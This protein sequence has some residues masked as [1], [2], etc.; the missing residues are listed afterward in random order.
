MQYVTQVVCY[1]ASQVVSRLGGS[2][3]V[4]IEASEG[5]EWEETAEAL[6][7]IFLGDAEIWYVHQTDCL[8]GGGEGRAAQSGCVRGVSFNHQYSWQQQPSGT[9]RLTA[10]LDGS[11]C[12]LPPPSC[13]ASSSGVVLLGVSCMLRECIGRK[14]WN[15]PPFVS[16]CCNHPYTC[17]RRPTSGSA[18][19]RGGQAPYISPDGHNICDIRFYEGLKLFGEDEPVRHQPPYMTVT[20]GW[21]AKNWVLMSACDMKGKNPA[22]HTIHLLSM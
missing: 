18:N 15:K 17:R 5:S 6:D 12:T 11:A 21:S 13:G 9:Q 7:D 19:P 4:F 20:G 3:P 14:M 10:A 8:Y 16:V 22:E 2:L 1:S